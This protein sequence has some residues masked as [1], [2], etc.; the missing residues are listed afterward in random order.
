M[1]H[2]KTKPGLQVSVS[3]R[4]L[5]KA[6]QQTLGHQAIPTPYSMTILMSDDSQ[7]QK[8]N[9]NY[10]QIDTPTDV[11]SFPSGETDL[12]T[13]E[14]YLGD[15]IISVPRAEQQAKAARHPFEA[16]VQLLVVHGV[17]HLLGHDHATAGEKARMWKAQ[18]EILN[19]LGLGNIQVREE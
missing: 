13:G 17:L 8:L 7:L 10:L 19:S 3:H 15:V 18:E 4:M 6:A 5:K 9:R 1:I 11:L 2:V 14:K 12:E 16:E